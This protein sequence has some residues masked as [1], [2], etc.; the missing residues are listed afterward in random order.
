MAKRKKSRRLP[1]PTS[2]QTRNRSDEIS[3]MQPPAPITQ[4]E[5]RSRTRK[6]IT[7]FG[8]WALG[9][10]FDYLLVGVGVIVIPPAIA[11]WVY[12]RSGRA[13]LDVSVVLCCA[14]IHSC[15][16]SDYLYG[17]TPES[18]QGATRACGRTGDQS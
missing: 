9:K 14:R 8:E 12:F 2:N 4:P 6:A 7:K 3:R 16:C 13:A 17:V 5:N 10:A 11:I 18:N 15:V 1:S